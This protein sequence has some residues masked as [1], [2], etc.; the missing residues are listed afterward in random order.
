LAAKKFLNS[1]RTVPKVS[2]CLP[3]LNTA[4][5]LPERLDSILAQNLKN[6]ELIVYDSFS[7]D[8]AWEVFQ[9]YAAKDSRIQISQGPRE[10]IY[11]G[12][13]ACISKAQGE[14]IYIATSD[15]TMYP[16][17]FEKMV[18][19]LDAHPECGLCQCALEII[20]E[21]SKLHP[22]RWKEFAFGR[23]APEW[24]ETFHVRP[25]PVDGLLHCVLQTVYTSITQLLI[26]KT[27][28]DN[29]GLFET[30]WGS[31][32]DFEW[33]MRVGFLESCVY[34]PEFLATWR[35]H[36]EQATG[37]SESAAARRKMLAMSKV[38]YQ[39]AVQFN[40]SI[41]NDLPP[42]SVLLQFYEEQILDFGLTENQGRVSRFRFLLK[43]ARA[44][45]L[46]AWRFILGLRPLKSMGEEVQFERLWK[47]FREMRLNL[48][49]GFRLI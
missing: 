7:D 44:G 8:G 25:A 32:A 24:V 12:F 14:F 38:A 42:K 16:E 27:V 4:K 20:D 45:N 47:A 40:P 15:D 21:N 31:V 39:K 37:L 29:Y 46:S 6:W 2:I 22:Y 19:A 28:F 11:A 43:E 49:A 3:N 48:P 13:N 23:F 34:I 10:G 1:S 26:R 17:C 5:Y 35:K 30:Q 18:A 41:V 9:S 36:P 33:G